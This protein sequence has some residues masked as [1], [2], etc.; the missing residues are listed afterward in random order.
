[1]ERLCAQTLSFDTFVLQ[2]V[3]SPYEYPMSVTVNDRFYFTLGAIGQPGFTF[4]T[5]ECTATTSAVDPAQP[6]QSYT[7]LRNG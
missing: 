3:I 1:M 7:F 5:Q 6:P 4:F 2:S